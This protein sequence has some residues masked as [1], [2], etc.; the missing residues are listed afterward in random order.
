M[1]TSVYPSYRAIG[2][3]MEYYGLKGPYIL[4]AAASLIA[5]LLLFVILYCC[6]TPPW[7]CIVIAF[8]LG[9][10]VIA[11][12]RGLSRRFGANG[13]TKHLAARRIPDVVRFESRQ[14]YLNLIKK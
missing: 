6:G 8:G 5:D 7:L 12:A 1:T 10:A 4:L 9:A 2:R 13:L 14:V 3:P 11:T